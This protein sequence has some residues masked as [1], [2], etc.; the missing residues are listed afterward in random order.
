MS[1]P[2]CSPYSPSECDDPHWMWY[3][4][5]LDLGSVLKQ[6]TIGRDERINAEIVNHVMKRSSGKAI[7]W[8]VGGEL[9]C[10]VVVSQA[11]ER[12]LMKESTNDDCCVSTVRL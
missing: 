6:I 1:R 2:W 5:L 3:W 9:C 12:S 4:N 11:L 8:G 7:D 10:R